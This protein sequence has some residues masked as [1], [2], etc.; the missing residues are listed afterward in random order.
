[1]WLTSS[2]QSSFTGMFGI[3]VLLQDAVMAKFSCETANA[4]LWYQKGCANF[5]FENFPLHLTA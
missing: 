4:F 1:M 2:Y 3:I 5:S